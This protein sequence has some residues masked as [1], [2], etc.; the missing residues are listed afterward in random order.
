MK[1]IWKDVLG[2]ENYYQVSNLG[3]VKSL[4]RIIIRG[5]GRSFTVNEK[6]LAQHSDENGYLMVTLNDNK[7]NKR[8]IKVH[9][10]VAIAFLHH[11][12]NKME[13]VIDHIDNDKTNNNVNNLQIITNRENVS[14]DRKSK[15]PYTGVCFDI[16]K[17]K[18]RARIKL[19]YEEIWLGYTATEEEASVLYKLALKNLKFYTGNKDR[20]RKLLKD[21]L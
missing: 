21:K 6:I 9:K 15:S 19:N 17:S 11:V 5:N 20:F 1:E 7:K 12:P 10:L 16:Q 13:K 4:P 18:W 8:T 14:K 3:R 2:Y